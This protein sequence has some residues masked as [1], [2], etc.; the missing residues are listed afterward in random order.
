MAT[1]GGGREP[2]ARHQLTTRAADIGLLMR[3]TVNL[4]VSLVALADPLSVVL[5][6]G[7]YL[8]AVLAVWS[9]YRLV[10]RSQSTALLAADFGAVLAV[11]LAIPVLTP[12]ADFYTFN[13]APQAIAGTAVVSLSV[14]VSVVA[15]IPMTL[16]IAAAYAAGAAQVTG[17]EEVSSIDA[18]YYFAVQCAT[19]SII[20]F[21]LL[22]VAGAVD[23]ARDDRAEAEVAERV[24]HAVRDYEREQ[25]ALLHDTAASTL[26][27]VGQGTSLPPERLAAQASRDLHLLNENH[28]EAPPPRMDIVAALHECAGHLSTAVA[29]DGVDRLWL[30]GATAY[31]VISA[32]REAMTNVDRHAGATMLHITVSGNAIRLTD[33]G[34]GFDPDA[35]RRGHGVDESI[36]GRMTRAG[37]RARITSAP[38]AGTVVELTWTPTPPPNVPDAADPDRLIDRT[39]TRFGLA[40]TVY[41]VVNLAITVPQA[42]AALGFFAAFGALAAIPGILWRRWG[43][44]WPAAAAVLAVAIAQPALLPADQVVGYAHWAQGAIGWCV[45]PLLLALPTRTGAAVVTGYWLV[46]SAVLVFR[47]PSAETFVNIG[48]GTASILA[49]QVFALV[50]NGLMRE[51]ATVVAVE[52]QTRQRLVTRERVSQAL[53]AEYQRRYADIVANVVPLLEELTRGEPVDTDMQLRARAECRRLR[54]LFDQAGTF[55]HPLMQQIRPLIDAAEDRRIDVVIDVCGTLPDLTQ[56]QI[57]TLTTPLRDVLRRASN[58]ARIVVTATGGEVEVSAVVD[59]ADDGAEPAGLDGAEVIVLGREL[60][61]L[62]VSGAR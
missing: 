26:L 19:A 47:D 60:W 49:V 39:R 14:S 46:N 59:T 4:G 61:C 42:D 15:S 8:L 23:R 18:L 11:C 36:V 2:T 48:L 21:M 34:V 50:F 44:A 52:N 29:F 58:S 9:L 51:A 28:W 56:E 6:A 55:D 32:A 17:W 10:T 53:R 38:G 41:A 43:L 12:T 40:L 33:D 31:P 37:G 30:P 54:T 7:R 20:R 27:M 1:N 25:L 13:T 24:T 3:N 57:A 62:I 22:H 16:A 5:P 45:V 35:P